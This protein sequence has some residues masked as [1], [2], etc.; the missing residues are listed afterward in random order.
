MPVLTDYNQFS[1]RH[2]E[3]GSVCNYLAYIGARTPHNNQPY[4]E[5]LLLGIS[6]GVVMGYFSFAYQGY[7]PQC[8]I[9]TR[10][11]F[12]PLDRMLSRMGIVQQ[13]RQTSS[14]EKGVQNLVDLL[15]AG[16]PGIVWADMY[17]LPYNHLPEDAGMW[18]MFPVVVFGYD[19]EKDRVDIAD[20][21]RVPLTT[22]TGAF[23]AARQR[24]KKDKHRVV[25]L[26]PPDPD[27]IRSA[28]LQGITDCIKLFVEKPPKGS[29]NNFGLQAYR[30]WMELLTRP[31]AR[32]SWAREFPP[33]VKMYAGLTSAFNF[34]NTFGKNGHAERD[35]YADFLVEAAAILESPG[36]EEAA[37][38][39]KQSA[40][41]WDQLSQALLPDDL[42]PL[43][44]TR[45]LL[46][47]RRDVFC[48]QGN[49]GLPR[50]KEIDEE[51]AS[52]HDQMQGGFPL[53]EQGATE[54]REQLA[55]HVQDVHDI[56]QRAVQR[57]QAALAEG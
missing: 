13:I 51:L 14:A 19:M 41:S 6:G 8:N 5:A 45:R 55:G 28:V 2:W 21:A 39:F 33:G 1:G 32:L 37:A 7:D 20:R 30:W 40:E 26:E 11:T 49:D 36:L 34:I 54:F 3:T 27:K 42:A 56:E 53:D 15:E 29:A 24:V 31:K 16:R 25:A 4:S 48:G 12:D 47:E 50:I 18:A 38:I 57:M 17:S 43:G 23:E 22:T 10:N 44:E 52:I 46:L 35:V 9:L